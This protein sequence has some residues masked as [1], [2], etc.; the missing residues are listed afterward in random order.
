L[1]TTEPKS[2]VAF[3]GGR[4]AFL[5]VMAVLVLGGISDWLYL[6][7]QEYPISL[8]ASFVE[9][10]TSYSAA[11]LIA[12]IEIG[13]TFYFFTV[14]EI[15]STR[16]LLRAAGIIGA[17]GFLGYVFGEVIAGF[18]SL[19]NSSTVPILTALSLEISPLDL[20]YGN[21]LIIFLSLFGLVLLIGTLLKINPLP[22]SASSAS[23]NAGFV[24]GV[25]TSVVTTFAAIVCCGPLPAIIATASG[26]ASMSLYFTTLIT[27]QSLLVLLSVPVLAISIILADRRA[28]S[29]C[30][31]RN[32]RSYRSKGK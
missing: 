13:A 23:K 21:A 20:D 30:K 27:W 3:A 19:G 31:L 29:G 16:K 24:G 25:W 9:Y 18:L 22:R 17:V 26:V 8:P 10:L 15:G 7:V 32:A 5:S 2:S 12:G 28:R 4:L 1:Q 14:Y 11:F 6:N